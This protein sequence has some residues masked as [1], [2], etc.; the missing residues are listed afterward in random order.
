LWQVFG[1]VDADHSGGGR[2]A[3]NG[4]TGGDRVASFGTG[5]GSQRW[6]GEKG[7]HMNGYF[8]CSFCGEDRGSIAER[9]T[10]AYAGWDRLKVTRWIPEQEANALTACCPDHATRLVSQWLVTGDLMSPFAR[11][12]LGKRVCELEDETFAVA[13]GETLCEFA[14]HRESMERLLD[15]NPQFLDT[16]LEALGEAL[17]AESPINHLRSEETLQTVGAMAAD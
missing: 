10:V 1:A 11:A 15:E 17:G 16:M 13:D 8:G 5:I 3:I 12:V 7:R 14:V 4:K 6:V 2:S 9:L